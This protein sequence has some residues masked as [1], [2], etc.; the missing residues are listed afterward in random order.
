MNAMNNHER[1]GGVAARGGSDRP[2]VVGL[3]RDRSDAEAAIRDLKSAGFG[4]ND[5]GAAM[6][7]RDQQGELVDEHG[8]K[9]AEGATTGAVSGGVVGGVLGFLAGVGALAIPGIGP[10]VAAGWLGSTL[11]GAGIGAAAG[12]MIGALVGMGIPEEDAR[13]FESGVKSGGVLVTVNAAGRRDEAIRILEARNADL[14]PTMRRQSSSGTSHGAGAMSAATGTERRDDVDRSRGDTNQLREEELDVRKER[15]QTGEVTLRTE[16]V[17]ENRTIDVPVTR[18]D[19]VIERHA[20]E[21]RDR[22]GGEIGEGREIRVPLSEERVHVDK[23]TVA[24]EEISVG[25][26]EVTGTGH[27]NEQVR[28]E[29]A[30]VERTGNVKGAADSGTTRY[31]GPERRLRQNRSYSGPERR[32]AMA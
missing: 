9:A 5:I 16:V 3:F 26:R 1:Q 10:I 31:K 25:K 23:N 32:L 12:G 24:R 21:G 8:T 6:R 7:D 11:A 19:V 29:E 28:R 14:G 17:T 30:R 15:V 27:V 22:A 18:E 2:T 20:V 4:E 13:H